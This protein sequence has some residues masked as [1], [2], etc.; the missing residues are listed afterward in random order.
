MQVAV[1]SIKT[2]FLPEFSTCIF[3]VGSGQQYFGGTISSEVLFTSCVSC[4]LVYV[5]SVKCSMPH[6]DV[7]WT[8]RFLEIKDR[9]FQ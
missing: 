6:P 1:L 2:A 3:P 8:Y 4:E 7:F 9:I 5:G